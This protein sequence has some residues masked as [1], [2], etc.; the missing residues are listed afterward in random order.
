MTKPRISSLMTLAGAGIAVAV[1]AGA[2]MWVGASPSRVEG[3][4]QSAHPS[5]VRLACPSGIVDPFE[6]TNVAAGTTWSSLAS[7]PTSPAPASVTG[8]GGAIP[9][10]LTLA[11]QGGGELAGLSAVGCAAPRTSQWIATG[12]TISGADMVLILSNPGPTASVVSIDD[13]GR[14]APSTPHHARSLSPPPP[15]CRFFSRDGSPTKSP[16]PYTCVQMG[17]GSPPGCRPLS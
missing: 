1:M 15:R 4:V 7:V 3:T 13:T 2:S 12:A 14:P 11:G 9:S 17:E 6:T 16:L 5:Q 10:A 8:N